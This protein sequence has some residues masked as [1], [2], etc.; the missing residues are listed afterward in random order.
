M[1]HHDYIVR[2]ACRYILDRIHFKDM[3]IQLFD[4]EVCMEHFA[5]GVNGGGMESPVTRG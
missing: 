4:D 5:T 2:G 1:Q 3:A